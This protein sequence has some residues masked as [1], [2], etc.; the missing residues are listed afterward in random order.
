[1]PRNG[2]INLR[3][4][5]YKS[6]CCGNEIIVREGATFPDCK[7]HPNLPTVW[8]PIDLAKGAGKDWDIPGKKTA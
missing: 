8:K 2:E 5:V 4:G 1:M 3:F 6:L 7:R